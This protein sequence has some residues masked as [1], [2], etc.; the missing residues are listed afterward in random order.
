MIKIDIPHI[1]RNKNR[2]LK[3]MEEQPNNALLQATSYSWLLFGFIAGV[4]ALQIAR[5]INIT[6]SGFSFDWFTLFY[7]II[8]LVF[9]LRFVAHIM[10]V[11][12]PF[13][14]SRYEERNKTKIEEENDAHID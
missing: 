4:L 1:V 6:E 12:V 3:R 7:S 11:M 2:F 13:W 9:M 8:T 14:E 5:S 10:G